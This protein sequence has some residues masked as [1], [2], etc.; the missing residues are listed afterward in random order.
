[1]ERPFKVW[2]WVPVVVFLFSLYLIVSPVISNPD[3]G[4]LFV[5]LILLSGLVF[6][7]PI[8]VWNVT[9]FDKP[10]DRLTLTLQKVLQLAPSEVKID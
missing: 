10:M 4:Y 2:I 1:M 9:Y 6:Y 3:L 7:I 5:S 8:H